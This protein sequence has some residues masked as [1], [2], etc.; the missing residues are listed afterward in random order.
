M[1]HHTGADKFNC[2]TGADTVTDFDESEGDRQTKTVR[3]SSNLFSLFLLQHHQYNQHRRH[4]NLKSHQIE[5]TSDMIDRL[6]IYDPDLP[7]RSPPAHTLD[8][9]PFRSIIKQDS[10]QYYYCTLHPNEKKQI[11]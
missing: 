9:S 7:Y 4:S 1:H 6:F 5:Q 3:T 10:N 11:Y 2:G 8:E